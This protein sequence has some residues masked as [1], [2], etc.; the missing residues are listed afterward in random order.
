MPQQT[1]SQARVIDPILT[2]VAR[3]YRSP[4]A[5][6][7]DILF[8]IVGVGARG[9][10]ILAFGADDFKLISTARAPGANTKR[11]QFGYS[12]ENYSLVD[13]RLEGSV[14]VELMQEAE[15]VPGID[16]ASTAVRRVQNIMALERE[17]KAA[18][19][20]R[21]AA[22]YAASNKTTLS[23]TSQ[24]SNTA[25]DPFTDINDAREAIRSQTGEKPNVLTLG[26]KV[27]TSLRSHPKILDRLSTAS[28]RPPATIQQ[29]QALFELQ[30]IV[31]G[32]AVYHDGTQFQDVWGKDA[33][34]AFTTP[35][36]MQEMGSPNFGYTY[37]LEDYPVVEEGYLDRNTNTW[38][39]PTA[40]AVQPVFTGPS[41]GF[42]FKD[43]AA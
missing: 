37:Q 12:S 43:A 20:A 40:D 24:W 41:A 17:H 29:L 7:A 2:A 25:S 13:H 33:I 38:Y 6:I 32:E 26:P 42:L 3:G 5:A 23:G 30:Q 22:K 35:A 1:T 27:L 10:R 15:A 34:L 14:P 21:D 39:Y 19:L 8:P 11:I 31:E 28:D 16:L 18:T 9:G 4:K 36:S